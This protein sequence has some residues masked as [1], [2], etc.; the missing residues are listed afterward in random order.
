[1][2]RVEEAEIIIK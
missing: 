1:M 2:N